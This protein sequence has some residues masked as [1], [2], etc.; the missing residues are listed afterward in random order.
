M[1]DPWFVLAAVLAAGASFL[2]GFLVM[3]VVLSV[4]A[5]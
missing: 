2:M 4:V 3:L 1:V 5:G